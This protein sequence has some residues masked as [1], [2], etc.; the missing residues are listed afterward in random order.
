MVLIYYFSIFL[1]GKA[2][3]D[4]LEDRYDGYGNPW[5]GYQK[6]KIKRTK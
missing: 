2:D 5:K 1:Y 4:T 6:I 3:F